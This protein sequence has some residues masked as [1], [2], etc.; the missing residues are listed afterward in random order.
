MKNA[1]YLVHDSLKKIEFQFTLKNGKFNDGNVEDSID[2]FKVAFGDLNHD[3][4]KDA[5]TVLSCAHRGSQPTQYL[6][7]L[8]NINGRAESGKPVRLG[9]GAQINS[10]KIWPSGAVT[11]DELIP[12]ATDPSGSATEHHK[13]IARWDKATGNL[14]VEKDITVKDDESYGAANKDAHPQCGPYTHCWDL[15]Y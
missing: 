11:V 15:E 12:A 9:V 7:H 8:L 5:V 10:I 14:T 4:W 13:L 3:H 2:E 1:R 6:A